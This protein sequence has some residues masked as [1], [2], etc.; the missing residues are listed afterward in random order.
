MK[1]ECK[2]KNKGFKNERVDVHYELYI[3]IFFLLNLIEDYILLQLLKKYLLIRVTNLRV[4]MGAMTGAFSVCLLLVFPFSKRIVVYFILHGFVNTGM[5]F[6]GL[7]IRSVKELIKG[8]IFLYFAS[9][10]MGGL[11]GIFAPYL[12]KIAVFIVVSV[13]GYYLS[14]II[15]DCYLW[16][17]RK[18]MYKYQ[19]KL[20]HGEK[21][22]CGT[23]LVDT[24]NCLKDPLTQRPIHIVSRKVTEAL[25]LQDE[26]YAKNRKEIL[27]QSLGNP[28]GSMQVIEVDFLVILNGKETKIYKN[29][30]VGFGEYEFEQGDFDVILN[31]K[32]VGGI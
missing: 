7:R 27:Y 25:G 20:I 30:E 2:I 24:G 8:L 1:S 9:L 28:N 17:G 31:P 10:I 22:F 15:W 26:R 13:F 12:D 29:Q 21:D 6:V 5:L 16:L 32:I 19:V 18:Q 23:A 3:D 4:L 11:L 14:L